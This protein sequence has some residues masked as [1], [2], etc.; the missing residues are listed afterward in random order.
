MARLTIVDP[1]R[2]PGRRRS[3]SAYEREHGRDPDMTA[4]SHPERTLACVEV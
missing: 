4:R 1:R 2:A 3:S